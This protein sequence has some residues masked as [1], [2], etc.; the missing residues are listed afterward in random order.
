[1]NQVRN[2]YR[3]VDGEAASLLTNITAPDWQ[4]GT[5]PI[6]YTDDTAGA[7]SDYCYTVTQVNSTVESGASNE[8]CA[9]SSTAKSHKH[10]RI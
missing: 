10:Q 1:M 6:D 7:G 2:I 3:G 9:Y 5:G 8:A 4:P